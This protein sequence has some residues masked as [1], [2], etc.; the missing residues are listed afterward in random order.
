MTA[1]R[2]RAVKERSTRTERSEPRSGA[3]DDRRPRAN[4]RQE[5]AL[6]IGAFVSGPFRWLLGVL[7]AVMA[8][9]RPS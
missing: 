7:A 6:D 9:G 1:R 3:L 2:R 4:L 5:V 8:W